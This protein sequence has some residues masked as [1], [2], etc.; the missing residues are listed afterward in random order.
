MKRIVVCLLLLSFLFPWVRVLAETTEG[1]ESNIGLVP[2]ARSAIMIDANTGTILYN[3]NANQIT[4][5]ASLTKMMGLIIIFEA[6]ESGKFTLDDIVTV[7]SNAKNMGGTQIWLEEGEKISVRDLIKG[8]TMASANDAMVAM[9]EKVAGTESAFVDLM[10]KKAQ[11]LGLKNTNFVNSTGLD[12]EGHY[13]TAYDVAMIAK[14]LVKHEDVLEFTKVYEA[15][16]REG[17]DNETWISNTNKLVRFYEGADGLKTGYTD[18]ALS[19]MAVTAKK[20]H[21]RLIAVTLGYEKVATR[22]T[23]AMALLDYGFNQ[24]EARR[25]YQKGDIVGRTKLDGANYS[26]IDLVLSEEV[27]VLKKK[28]EEDKNYLYEIKVDDL[29]LPIQKGDKVGTFYVKSDNKTIATVDLLS[30][31]DAS[32]VGLFTFCI[33][34]IFSILSGGEVG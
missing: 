30:S 21:L 23:E 15:Y 7:S 11:E 1:E 13:S 8:I 32:K 14:E 28:G 34:M 26:S 6:L 31:T 17:T 19:C 25:L 3:K 2:N 9:A 10:N 18:E 5:I 27:V 4:S 33:N 20:G 16:I 29:T 24:Y 22:N 12:E